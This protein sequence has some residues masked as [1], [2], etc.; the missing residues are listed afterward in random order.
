MKCIKCS[1]FFSNFNQ[2]ILHLE[3]YH[4]S[5][6]NY[7]VCPIPS[8]SRI[9][10][11]KNSLKQHMNTIHQANFCHDN[12][13]KN[14]DDKNIINESYSTSDTHIE[15]NILCESVAV[16]EG[17]LQKLFADF[18]SLFTISIEKLI[19][20]FYCNLG[21]PRSVIQTLIE[22]VSA[23]MSSGLIDKMLRVS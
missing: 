11:R 5:N 23:F 18:Q 1:K 6:T 10:H 13:A 19:S 14:T 3:C 12:L 21:V 2:Y 7:F 9:Y 4:N 20:Q 8:C 17:N 15:D 22:S 16:T